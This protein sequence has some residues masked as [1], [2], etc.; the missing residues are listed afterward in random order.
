VT[1][2]PV[3]S[4]DRGLDPLVRSLNVRGFR[5]ERDAS[6]ISDVESVVFI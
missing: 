5:E 1:K 6:F 2:F 4:L 3:E